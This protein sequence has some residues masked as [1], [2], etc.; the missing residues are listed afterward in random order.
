MGTEATG[1]TLSNP[2]QWGRATFIGDRT[3]ESS[4]S[5]SSPPV[6]FGMLV[7]GE[8]DKKT[9]SEADTTAASPPRSAATE[10]DVRRASWT[11]RP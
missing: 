9:E 6:H 8:V 4:R 1:S 7:E 10:A 11:M 3:N 2:K 5:G